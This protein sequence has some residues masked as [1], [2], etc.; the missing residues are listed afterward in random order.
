LG[1]RQDDQGDN[2]E[3]VASLFAA[4]NFWSSAERRLDVAGFAKASLAYVVKLPESYRRV[5]VR[6]PTG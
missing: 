3:S 6:T 4:G 5:T 1:Q 2:W